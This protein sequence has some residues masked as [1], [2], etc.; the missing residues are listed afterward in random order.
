MEYYLLTFSNTHGA[1]TA[2]KYLKDRLSF[3]VMP[4]LREI[5]GSCGISLKITGHSIETIRCLMKCF[6]V[7]QAMYEIYLVTD[8]G[9]QLLPK[10][11]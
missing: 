2:Q 5:S 3:Y 9:P 6:P 11:P 10:H 4:T 1:I 8:T 7:N